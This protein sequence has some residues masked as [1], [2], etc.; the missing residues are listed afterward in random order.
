LT[1]EKLSSCVPLGRFV[2]H[3]HDCDETVPLDGVTIPAPS[4]IN[5]EKSPVVARPPPPNVISISDVVLVAVTD[6]LEFGTTA[7]T[8][9]VID[10]EGNV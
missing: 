1:D 2:V 10:P 3:V 5:T 7:V 4:E 9:D 8:N 6:P